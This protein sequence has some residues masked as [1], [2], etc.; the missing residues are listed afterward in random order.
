MLWFRN[1]IFSVLV[2]GTVAIWIPSLMRNDSMGPVWAQV[3]G[4]MVCVCG[5]L[6]YSASVFRFGQAGGTPAIF[7]TR[8]FRAVVGEEPKTLVRSGPYRYS[9]NPMY[10]GVLATIFG[11]AIWYAS[12]AIAVY[13]IF[14]FVFLECAVLIIEEPHLKNRDPEK[15]RELTTTVPRWFGIPKGGAAK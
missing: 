11:Q 13:G 9:R 7:F 10:L 14:V 6:L 15:F 1:I 12:M 2:P 3:L 4:L 5:V 8:P